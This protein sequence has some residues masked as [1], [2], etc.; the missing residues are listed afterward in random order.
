MKTFIVVNE[1][2]RKLTLSGNIEKFS[3]TSIDI[4][5]SQKLMQIKIL[6][7]KAASLTVLNKCNVAAQLLHFY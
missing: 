1:Q 4:L 7:Q 2:F 6:L 3:R 5:I